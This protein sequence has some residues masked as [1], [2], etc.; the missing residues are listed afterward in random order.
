MKKFLLRS[1]YSVINIGF[2]PDNICSTGSTVANPLAIGPI[3]MEVQAA[4]K[5]FTY[6]SLFLS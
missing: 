3:A 5:S 6:G 1:I 2:W 4:L